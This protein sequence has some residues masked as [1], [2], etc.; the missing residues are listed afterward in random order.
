MLNNDHKAR[1]SVA[2][3][4]APRVVSF[5]YLLPSANDKTVPLTATNVMVSIPTLLKMPFLVIPSNDFY[6]GFNIIDRPVSAFDLIA[7]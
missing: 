1:K 4:A 2:N 5:R 7:E 6:G 3:T